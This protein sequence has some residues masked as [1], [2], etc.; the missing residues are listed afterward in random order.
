MRGGSFR[1]ARRAKFAMAAEEWF[2][3]SAPSDSVSTAD[4]WSALCQ[5]YPDLTTASEHRK[6]PR[7]TFKR[8]IR[9]DP[10]FEV[11]GGKVRLRG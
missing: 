2:K 10:L 7:A 6:T 8:D 1:M 3:K 4:L 9:N 11:G 5:F